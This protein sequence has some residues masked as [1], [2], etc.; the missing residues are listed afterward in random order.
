MAR[1]ALVTGG[2]RG[3]GFEI[4]RLL[5]QKGLTVVLGARDLDT[6]DEAV[7]TL[8]SDGLM[9]SSQ[10]IDVQDVTSIKAASESLLE[11][12]GVIDVLVNNA[13]VLFDRRILPTEIPY[14][15]LISTITTNTIGPFLL[16]QA[17]IPA[18]VQAG[19]G[20]VVNVSSILGALHSMSAKTP[21]YAVSKAGLNA[22][23]RVFAAETQGTNVKVNS[24]HPGRVHTRMGSPDAP[25]TP[26]QG[27]DTAVWLAT[28]PDDGPTGG[29]FYERQPIDW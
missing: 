17:F 24:M 16:C 18:M 21:A 29:F 22:I 10:L 11:T 23:T 6:A 19:Y 12:Y 20:R 5:A 14:D 25:L 4:C 15:M 27:A 1:T 7:E 2:N 13:G 8:R 9:V 3:I 28:L 26:R